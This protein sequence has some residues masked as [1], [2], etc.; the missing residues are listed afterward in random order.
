M[1][2]AGR[3]FARGIHVHLRHFD[4]GN[5]RQPI[6]LCP[7]GRKQANCAYTRD[8]RYRRAQG[9]GTCFEH[10]DLRDS[11]VKRV[12]VNDE[13]GADFASGDQARSSSIMPQAYDG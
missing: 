12:M 5:V 7:D 8:G 4:F 3:G 6:L 2:T 9:K 10:D 13:N 1:N 11:D